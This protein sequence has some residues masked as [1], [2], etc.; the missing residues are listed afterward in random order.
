[1][2]KPRKLHIDITPPVE[3]R[4]GRYDV[5]FVGITLLRP[6]VMIEYDITPPLRT[7]TPFGPHVVILEV[8]DDTSDETYP[9]AWLDFQ[10]PTIGEGRTTTRLERRPPA[11]AK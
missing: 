4:I 8:T 10:W 5:A 7:E 6:H 11:E 3:V 2:R 1:M 9:T